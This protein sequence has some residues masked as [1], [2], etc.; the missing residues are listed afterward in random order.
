M[1]Q[2]GFHVSKTTISNLGFGSN[3]LFP[4]VID[5][6]QVSQ[7]PSQGRLT[8]I[9][10]RHVTD[11]PQPDHEAHRTRL[12][13]SRVAKSNLFGWIPFQFVVQ[14]WPQTFLLTDKPYIDVAVVEHDRF[15][16]GSLIAWVATA[17]MFRQTSLL[18]KARWRWHNIIMP[19]VTVSWPLLIM[20]V[21]KFV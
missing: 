10:M 20:S 5:F 4:W 21:D 13:V 3:R 6:H 19:V 11:K 16:G 12:S 18:C 9:C 17:W 14:W 1:Y 2:D 8:S 7:N 15:D